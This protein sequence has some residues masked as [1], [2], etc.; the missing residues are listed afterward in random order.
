[1]FTTSWRNYR[2]SPWWLQLITAVAIVLIVTAV[3]VKLYNWATSPP[4]EIAST[5]NPDAAALAKQGI[6]LLRTA[7]E[8]MQ[9]VQA[10]D[11]GMLNSH[12]MQIKSNTDDIQS[13]KAAQQ[14]NPETFKDLQDEVEALKKVI[15]VPPVPLT[16][17]SATSAPTK[18]S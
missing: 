2:Y 4:S 8:Q 6:S 18:T 14:S 12:S 16:P 9:K 17:M 15:A 7:I 11:R 3:P 10:E 5:I 1:M 13:I